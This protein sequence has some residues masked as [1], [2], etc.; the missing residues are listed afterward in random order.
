MTKIDL[1]PAFLIHRR[2]F[3]NNSLLLDFFTRD[4]GKIRLVGRGIRASKTNIQMFQRLNISFAGK[5]E[6]KTLTNW[7]VDDMPR[8]LA[9]KVLILGLYV[10]ELIVRLLHEN[11]A[12]I[13]LFE[14]YQQLIKQISDLAQDEQAWLLRLFE[15]NLLTELGYGL[16][17]STDIEQMLIDDNSFYQYQLQSGFIKHSTGK[18][19]GNLLKQMSLGAL[20]NMPDSQQLKIC[21]NLNR[22]RLSELL[23][24]KPLQSRSLFFTGT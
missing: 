16:D 19:S 20:N 1:T 11:D 24:D 14:S 3:K 15:N 9:G 22:Q 23:G 12:H 13:D 2:V 21:R 10:N 8:V 7:E 5:S 6:L 18:I 4:Y 17:F